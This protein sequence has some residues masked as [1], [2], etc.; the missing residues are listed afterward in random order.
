MPTEGMYLISIVLGLAML[1]VAII[2][3][4]QMHQVNIYIEN[5]TT[6]WTDINT[7]TIFRTEMGEICDKGYK[8]VPR[9]GNKNDPNISKV[10]L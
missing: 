4:F 1:C 5:A 10:E 9:D 8:I 7:H 3:W 6:V 2:K